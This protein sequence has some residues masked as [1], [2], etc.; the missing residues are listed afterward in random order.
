[1][2]EKGQIIASI[3]AVVKENHKPSNTC[4][5]MFFFGK[6]NDDGDRSILFSF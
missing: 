4:Q 2:R 6:D 1:M 5:V 3:N